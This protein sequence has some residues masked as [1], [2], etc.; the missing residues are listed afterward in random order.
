MTATHNV[1]GIGNAIV[2]I[3]VHADDD[4]LVA[5]GLTKGSMTLIDAARADELYGRMGPA[6]EISGGSA[7]NTMAGVASLGG[8]AAY[9]GKICTDQLGEVFRHDIRAI[10]VDF[11]T[12]PVVGAPPTARSLIVVTPDGQRTMNTMLGACVELG[13]ADIDE[14][15]ITGAQVTYMEGYLWD[16]PTAKEAFLKAATIAHDAG[17]RVSLTLSDTFCV[18]RHRDSFRD[19]VAGHVDILF[20]NDHEVMAL[21]QVGSLDEAVDAVRGECEVAAITRGAKGSLILN[22]DERFE[23]AAEPVARIVDSTGAGD[24]YAAGF[25]YGFTDG[26]HPEEC[27]RLGSI[28]AAEVISHIGAR[29][30]GSL[31]KLTARSA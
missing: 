2:D 23:V 10:G 15:A 1:V 28:A 22:G 7:A 16:K 8:R 13:P 9:I 5:N 17:R 18:E 6:I 29:P 14:P 4:F 12:A 27:G 26:R 20:G 11:E 21:Y 25:L 31:A 24:L 3:L 19:L 30:E